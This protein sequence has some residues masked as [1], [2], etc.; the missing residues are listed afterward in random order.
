MSFSSRSPGVARLRS[1]PSL[2]GDEAGVE[3]VA[4]AYEPTAA[5]I[6][7]AAEI[8][9]PL[10]RAMTPHETAPTSATA[11]QMTMLRVRDFVLGDSSP[12]RSP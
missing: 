4:I 10:T 2:L 1:T 3:A 8:C 12:D 9:S 5:A 11:V 7:H 6:S